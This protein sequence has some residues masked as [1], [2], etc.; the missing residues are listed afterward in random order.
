MA[1]TSWRWYNSS[2]SVLRKDL[3]MRCTDTYRLGYMLTQAVDLLELFINGSIKVVLFP[4]NYLI[5]D[6]YGT[7]QESSTDEEVTS[8]VL[9][10]TADKSTM[11]SACQQPGSRD[12]Q[13]VTASSPFAEEL[14]ASHWPAV[15]ESSSDALRASFSVKSRTLMMR[16][17]QNIEASLQHLKVVC[18]MPM[19]Y[20]RPMYLKEK[21]MSGF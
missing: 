7:V 13:P 3:C 14:L 11:D 18:P 9:Q 12:A 4:G 15:K 10:C 1:G 19:Y 20:L 16:Y 21:K 5:L 17:I 8:L 2:K 6:G